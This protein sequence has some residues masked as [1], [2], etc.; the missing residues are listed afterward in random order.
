MNKNCVK[1][2]SLKSDTKPVTSRPSKDAL[3][4]KITQGGS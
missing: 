1:N 3:S 4:T 2:M